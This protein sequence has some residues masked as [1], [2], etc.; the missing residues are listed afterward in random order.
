M[1]EPRGPYLRRK[2]LV[3]I[4]LMQSD[5]LIHLGRD[6]FGRTVFVNRS[7]WTSRIVWKSLV[8]PFEKG[9]FDPTPERV[10]RV[11]HSLMTSQ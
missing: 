1:M 10:Y 6:M 2:V 3:H 7:V 11:S 5:E 9:D 8:L 4:V